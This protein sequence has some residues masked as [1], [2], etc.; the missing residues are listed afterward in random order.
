MVAATNRPDLLDAALVRPGRID[1]KVPYFILF[2]NEFLSINNILQIYVP[3]PDEAS[4]LQIFALEFRK[5]P[6]HED[7]EL[8][9]CV[10]LSAGF[11]GAEISGACTEAAMLAIEREIQFAEA[12]ENSGKVEVVSSVRMEDLREALKATQPQIT[13]QM[14]AFYADLTKKLS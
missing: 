3:P 2:I 14:L 11:S 1:R 8:N 6:V 12:E 4:R 9:E 13:S 7:V 5:M 10:A